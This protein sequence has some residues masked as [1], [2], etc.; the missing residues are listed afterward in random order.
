MNK[1]EWYFWIGYQH[2]DNAKT[3]LPFIYDTFLTEMVLTQS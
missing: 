1:Q 2:K 3:F